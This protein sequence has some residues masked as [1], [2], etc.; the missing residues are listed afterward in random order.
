[1][2]LTAWPSGGAAGAGGAP[3]YLVG[4]LVSADPGPPAGSGLQLRLRMSDAQ[5]RASA[6][7][8]P[9]PGEGGPGFQAASCSLFLDAVAGPKVTQ[10]PPRTWGATATADRRVGR[11]RGAE[12]SGLRQG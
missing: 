9:A 8:A 2:A 5:A 1:V 7:A 12:H 10:G 3:R 11:L 4:E 6:P